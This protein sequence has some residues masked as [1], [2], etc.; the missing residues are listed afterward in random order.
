M[1]EASRLPFSAVAALV[2]RVAL[3]GRAAKETEDLTLA[4]DAGLKAALLWI[5]GQETRGL[6]EPDLCCSD[7][8]A[9]RDLSRQSCCA[10]V[11][12]KRFGFPDNAI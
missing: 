3:E 4:G 8:A 9:L 5:L 2:T 11:L 6:A 1:L 10:I 12:I 7:A